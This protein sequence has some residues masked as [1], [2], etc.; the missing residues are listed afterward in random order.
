M[1][2]TGKLEKKGAQANLPPQCNLNEARLDPQLTPRLIPTLS[3]HSGN[4]FLCT[5]PP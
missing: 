5:L 1:P 3:P 4:A 2:D